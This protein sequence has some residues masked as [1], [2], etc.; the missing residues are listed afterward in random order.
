[1]KQVQVSLVKIFILITVV[2]LTVLIFICLFNVQILSLPSK[3]TGQSIKS[4]KVGMNFNEVMAI[5]GRPNHIN[6]DYGRSH[7]ISCQNPKGF[8]DNDISDGDDINTIVS[9]FFNDKRSCCKANAE[10]KKG[11]DLCFSRLIP[12]VTCPTVFVSFD[13][14]F[15]VDMVHVSRKLGMFDH[16]DYPPIYHLSTYDNSPDG[17]VRVNPWTY[18]DQEAFVKFLN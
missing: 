16:A 6:T 3:V 11:F 1:M 18:I 8:L 17:P 9:D 5:L 2:F 4:I 13:S 14:T 15:K 10:D 7:M 12:F